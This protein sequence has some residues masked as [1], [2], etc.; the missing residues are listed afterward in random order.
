M[1]K[2]G[3]LELHLLNLERQRMVLSFGVARFDFGGKPF[4]TRGNDHRLQRFHIV[5]KRFDSLCHT[6]MES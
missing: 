1:A 2:P 5:R 3:D 6:A 4:G